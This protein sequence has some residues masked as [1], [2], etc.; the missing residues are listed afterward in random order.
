MSSDQAVC[1]QLML[2]WLRD[3]LQCE[4]PCSCMI[5]ASICWQ[6]APLHPHVLNAS[7]CTPFSLKTTATLIRKVCDLVIT[8]LWF[9]I[10]LSTSAVFCHVYI[11]EHSYV[12]VKAKVSST[13]QEI[14]KVVA[15]KLQRAEEDLA[16]VAIM[17]SGGELCSFL[18]YY[19][20]TGSPPGGSRVGQ[21]ASPFSACSWMTTATIQSA[22]QRCFHDNSGVVLDTEFPPL[23]WIG[24][25]ASVLKCIKSF[26]CFLTLDKPS[27]FIFKL[28]SEIVKGF[29]YCTERG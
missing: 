28:T 18:E 9:W 14:L 16:L 2:L 19:S 25:C 13:A 20:S 11:T 8:I 29:N 1:P 24:R 10:V 27:I 17:F 21:A 22:Y 3:P 26:L 4:K 15:E 5:S 6:A 12:S 7:S 23:N